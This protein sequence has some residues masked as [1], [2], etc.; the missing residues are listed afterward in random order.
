MY[1]VIKGTASRSE[2][3]S[4]AVATDHRS[5]A[6]L[7]GQ[8]SHSEFNYKRQWDSEIVPAKLKSE[9]HVLTMYH[10]LQILQS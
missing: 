4:F 10:P 2:R 8:A 9:Q 1:I 7:T 6:T 3:R 5:A